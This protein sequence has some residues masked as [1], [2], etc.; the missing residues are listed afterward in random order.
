MLVLAED[1]DFGVNGTVDYQM[2]D[3]KDKDN[4]PR[5]D[6]FNIDNKL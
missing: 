1:Y 2:T 3:V 6:Y 4:N 5:I